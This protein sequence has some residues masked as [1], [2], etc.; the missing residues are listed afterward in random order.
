MNY[1]LILALAAALPWGFVA[2]DTSQ[3]QLPTAPSSIKYPPP[4]PTP[5]PTTTQANP[6]PQTQ[7]PAN[8]QP[9]QTNGSSAASQNSPQSSSSTNAK[10]E[11]APGT[12]PATASGGD[13]DDTLTVIR[14]RVDEVNVVFT[15]TD[16]RDHFVKDL[17]QKD[18]RVIDD[19]K[20]ALSIQSFSR[21]T[22]LPLR[23]GLLIDASNSVRDRFKFE[24]EAAIEFLNQIV[25]PRYDKA[26]VIGFDTTPEV[27]QDFTDS[28]EQLSHGVR[29][30]RAGGGTAL[31][32]AIYFAARDKLMGADKGLLATRRAIILLSDGEDNQS[33]VSREE[34]VEM[35]QRAEV[36]IYAISTNVS[37][38]VTRGDKVLKHFAEET[39]GKA[40]FPFKIE[41][42]ANAFT[43]IS[44]E[45]R[46]QYA[47]SYKPADFLANGKYRSI[48]ILAENKKYHVRARKG[49]YAPRQ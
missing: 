26:F 40:F 14:K 17:T 22:N 7:A 48:E 29:M 43:E 18:F 41:D 24:Q 28:A 3:Q 15:V 16:K 30:L 12:K 13:V 34:A 44:D 10:P 46:S 8:S 19:S 25:R 37:G 2:Q 35:A 4:P 1:W 21:E 47:I 42:V 31:Y 6:A 11:T 27:T 5:A 32:D 23:V 36:I 49:Y 45:L 9:A 38:T 33:R 20:P 39:G